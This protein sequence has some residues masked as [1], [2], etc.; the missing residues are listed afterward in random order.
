MRD[1]IVDYVIH[2]IVMPLQ[3]QP[4]QLVVLQRYPSEST[5]P[6]D[7]NEKMWK[8]EDGSITEITLDEFDV[9]KSARDANNDMIW[10]ASQHSVRVLD[11]NEDTGEA[12]VEVDSIFGPMSMQGTIYRLAKDGDSWTI[13]K[14]DNA[15]GT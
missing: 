10:R 12:I 13:V 9:L 2:D 11:M 1:Q 14:K 5:D 4:T 6:V 7:V 3:Q 8:I 15:W